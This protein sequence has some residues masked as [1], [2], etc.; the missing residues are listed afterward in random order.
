MTF[1]KKLDR[2]QLKTGPLLQ[3]RDSQLGV[4]I[5]QTCQFGTTPERR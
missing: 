2:L 1:L 4:H 5:T 3:R